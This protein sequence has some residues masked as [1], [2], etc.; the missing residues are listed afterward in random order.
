MIKQL[1]KNLVYDFNIKDKNISKF[2]NKEQKNPYIG[3]ISYRPNKDLEY[4]YD[5]ELI[6]AEIYDY[7][8]KSINMPNNIQDKAEKVECLFDKNYLIIKFCNPNSENK[9][10][11]EIGN[12]NSEKIFKPEFFLLYDNLNYLN[13]HVQYVS[14]AGGFTKY[15]QI[16]NSLQANTLD[17]TD[18]NNT[19]FGIAIKKNMN[20]IF[21]NYINVNNQN[22]INFIQNSQNN[23]L[24]QNSQQNPINQTH[25]MINQFFNNIPQS[26]K[27]KFNYHPKI[28]LD[29]I[30][31]P[32][33]INPILQCFSNI[34]EFVSFFKY[35]NLIN[36]VNNKYNQIGKN[37]LSASFKILFDNIW[38]NNLQG[39]F[40]P[41]E[42]IDKTSKMSNLLQSNNIN[43]AINNFIYFIISTLHEELNQ[44]IGNTSIN[45]NN[46]PNNNSFIQEFNNFYFNFNN[47]F[48]SFISKL[49]YAIQMTE[50]TCLRCNNTQYNFQTYFLLNFSLFDVKKYAINKRQ[51]HQ[52]YL[53]SVN[54]SN[55]FSM[56]DINM[57]IFNLTNNIV[58]IF[59]CFD[60]FQKMETLSN[61]NS[62]YCYKCNQ[63][64]E[65]IIQQNYII[66]PKY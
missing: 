47:N 23:Q 31:A 32:C 15:C 46:N 5:F 49:F 52:Q 34:E 33:Y 38:S 7:L 9:Y 37:C 55:N 17:I 56:N 14:G 62:I 50:T 40:R 24:L 57:K 16:F 29:N 61:D 60:Y 6:N 58:D 26:I 41:L 3:T 30:G 12:L 18:N 19:K 54:N 22:N 53:M 51:F 21:N 36:I 66:L 27:Y 13:E 10:L 1:P 42:F 64:S 45:I 48:N 39:N 65:E 8:F 2:N 43:I 28:G 35:N 63:S 4:Y 44:N 11:L 20:I 25:M 59:D